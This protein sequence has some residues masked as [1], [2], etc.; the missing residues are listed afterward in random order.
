MISV[1]P[2]IASP[3]QTSFYF[4]VEELNITATA[5]MLKTLYI[6]TR[7]QFDNIQTSA[8]SDPPKLQALG[9]E[10]EAL[11]SFTYALTYI[12][13]GQ[14][15]A[16]FQFLLARAYHVQILISQAAISRSPFPCFVVPSLAVGGMSYN[17]SAVPSGVEA[18]QRAS[19][20]VQVSLGVKWYQCYASADFD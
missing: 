10:Q 8:L 20:R 18:G 2:A 3:D 11:Q 15:S 14:Y 5:G 9:A 16:Q 4:A 19:F 6:L 13:G 7:D 17:S 1:A 12:G